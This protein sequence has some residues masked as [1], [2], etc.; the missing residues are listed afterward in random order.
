MP[1]Q[2]IFWLYVCDKKYRKSWELTVKT[3]Q[4][5]DEEKNDIVFF[6]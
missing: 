4:K 1:G 3:R 6:L 2:N 5:T